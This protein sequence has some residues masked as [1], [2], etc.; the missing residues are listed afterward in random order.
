MVYTNSTSLWSNSWQQVKW[1]LTIY[2][3]KLLTLVA[4]Q[5]FFVLLGGIR[6][7][8]SSTSIGGFDIQLENYDLT[9]YVVVGGVLSFIFGTMI[10]SKSEVKA[11]TFIPMTRT[12]ANI[13]NSIVLFVI[14]LL[15]TVLCVCN[16]YISTA[17]STIMSND[18]WYI[19]VS[20]LFSLS[21]FIAAC[22]FLWMMSGIGYLFVSLN[23]IKWWLSI[24][25]IVI[26][27]LF[28]QLSILQAILSWF[29]DD[30]AS[31]FGFK[32]LVFAIFYY[33]IAFACTKKLEVSYK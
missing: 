5:L 19:D 15:N 10:G 28:N 6:T 31:L 27:L 4:I 7:S 22:F 25:L 2:R 17:F 9:M 24:S 13:S 18:N 20:Q 33:F 8:S 23:S 32:C 16:L 14:S 1:K 3:H 21:H 12:T 30:G 29:V 26:V 11:N